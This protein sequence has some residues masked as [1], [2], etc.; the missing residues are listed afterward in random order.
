MKTIRVKTDRGEVLL[1]KD[2]VLWIEPPKS[3]S[4][5][6]NVVLVGGSNMWLC[7]EEYERLAMDLER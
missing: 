6:S 7:A 5:Y 2:A 3:G 1:R 4:N